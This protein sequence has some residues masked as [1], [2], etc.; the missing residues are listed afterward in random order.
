MAQLMLI[1]LALGKDIGMKLLIK[2]KGMDGRA[3]HIVD[4][5]SKKLC[6]IAIKLSDWHIVECSP[7]GFVICYH[8]RRIQD[9]SM[10][11]ARA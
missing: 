4:A 8:C 5:Q 2:N 10:L 3:A 1:S 7:T 11:Q 9:K 6:K